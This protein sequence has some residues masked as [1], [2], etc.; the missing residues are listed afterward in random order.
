MNLK[1]NMQN[2]NMLDEKVCEKKKMSKILNKLYKM[3]KKLY[4]C[5]TALYTEKFPKMLESTAKPL[6]DGHLSNVI[7]TLYIFHF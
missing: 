7:N 1:I 4:N 5:T 6:T 3:M 2:V